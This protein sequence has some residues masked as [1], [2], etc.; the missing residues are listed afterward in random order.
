M[1]DSTGLIVISFL[2]ALGFYMNYYAARMTNDLGAQ[3]CTGL[4]DG[5]PVPMAQRWLMLYNQYTPYAVGGFTLTIWFGLAQLLLASYVS[6]EKVKALGYLAAFMVFVGSLMW[7]A[8]T[9]V[10]FLSYRSL[11]RQA[12]AD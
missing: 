5:A 9:S 4:V 8:H 3:I 10:T 2:G 12:E 6:D 1:S 7:L 11:L